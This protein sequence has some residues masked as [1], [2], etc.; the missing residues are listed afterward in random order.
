[1]E[2]ME[3]FSEYQDYLAQSKTYNC[4]GIEIIEMGIP[5]EITEIGLG[6]TRQLFNDW[7]ID[8]KENFYNKFDFGKHEFT[9]LTSVEQ[10]AHDIKSS[11]I[12]GIVDTDINGKDITQKLLKKFLKHPHKSFGYKIAKGYYLYLGNHFDNNF[13]FD[14]TDIHDMAYD[15]Y[16]NMFPGIWAKRQQLDKN[17]FIKK[18]CKETA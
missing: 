13:R 5:H 3:R 10:A 11:M 9:Y 17:A 2:I 7:N 4:E 15:W 18:L 6:W 14:K 8:R 1:M 16:H 12:M